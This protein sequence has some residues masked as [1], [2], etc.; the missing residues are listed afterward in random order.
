[1]KQISA[2]LREHLDK[3]VTALATCWQI[4]RR[5]GVIYRFTDCDNDITVDAQVYLAIGAYSRTAIENTASLAVDNLDIQGIVSELTLPASEL[6]AGAFDFAEVKVFLTPWMAAYPGMLKLRRGF[7][8]EIAVMPN[9]T[10]KAELRGLMQRFSHEFT[11]VYTA[12]CLNDLGDSNCGVYI[13]GPLLRAGASVSVGQTFSIVDAA[14]PNGP[15][16]RL[17][18]QDRD[19]ADLLSTGFGRARNWI[20]PETDG[21]DNDMA[22][23]STA[24]TGNASARGSLT[25]ASLA[26]DVPL[27][28]GRITADL[29]DSE[30]AYLSFWCFRRDTTASQGARARVRL[31]FMGY[32]RNVA[33]PLSTWTTGWQN[34]GDEWVMRGENDIAIPDG[35]RFVRI[36]FDTHPDD[37]PANVAEC[38]FDHPHGWM[39]AN[40][41]SNMV[42]ENVFGVSPFTFKA[43]TSGT[44]ADGFVGTVGGNNV[45][46]NLGSVV[47]QP[48]PTRND[49]NLYDFDVLFSTAPAR[50]HAAQITH[51]TNART[52]TVKF[53]AGGDPELINAFFELGTIKVMNGNNNGK[54]MEIKQYTRIADDEGTIELY[55]SLPYL[56]EIGDSLI[57][58]PGCDKSRVCCVALWDNIENFFATPD[59]PGEDST[60]EYPDFK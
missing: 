8:G 5:D 41:S 14:T 35:A 23:A 11:N 52:F 44:V 31:L 34:V 29:I 54:G 26:Q 28:G 30:D 6:R 24:Y 42:Q 18:V 56:L 51:V 22:T 47:R 10:F 16:E 3:G 49:D 45:T 40:D 37:T 27:I 55:L 21:A 17:Q 20:N 48:L 50:F 60:F 36:W 12:N 38:L 32:E 13:Y 33:D 2:P 9:G 25:G 39:I 53:P 43:E 15:R 59:V 4:K 57:V 19:F 7:F 46:Y 1:M 58:T